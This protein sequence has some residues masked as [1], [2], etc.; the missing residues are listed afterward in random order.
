MEIHD[1]TNRN[2]RKTD[3]LDYTLPMVYDQ[4]EYSVNMKKKNTIN[5]IVRDQLRSMESLANPATIFD[6]DLK[7]LHSKI[8]KLETQISTTTWTQ[9]DEP[10]GKLKESTKQRALKLVDKLVYMKQCHESM[11]SQQ[12]KL[13]EGNGE[14]QNYLNGENVLLKERLTELTAKVEALTPEMINFIRNAK[15]I[16]TT[17][18]AFKGISASGLTTRFGGA[19]N[20]DRIT[21]TENITKHDKF[22]NEEQ[23]KDVFAEPS[24]EPIT[25][26]DATKLAALFHNEIV[27]R[28]RREHQEFN[29]GVDNFSTSV[30]ET[31]R[32]LTNRDHQKQLKTP[33][34]ASATAE[35]LI[36]SGQSFVLFD[37][38]LKG[39]TTTQVRGEQLQVK[40]SQI[41]ALP[42]ESVTK[43]ITELA[44]SLEESKRLIR[45]VIR[46]CDGKV[47]TEFAKKFSYKSNQYA[48]K[49]KE[50]LEIAP[51]AGK[52]K[53]VSA[54]EAS[55]PLSSVNPA[56]VGDDDSEK[57]K[58][59]E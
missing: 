50:L 46:L 9:N 42:L 23:K 56:A 12:Q 31:N 3:Y 16:Y 13:T 37:K 34:N 11:M 7:K 52:A 43:K 45:D 38:Q 40:I 35:K 10:I 30:K 44:A 5:K 25:I 19:R 26:Q 20:V 33:E 22:F 1:K 21:L 41:I 55:A 57:K 36:E 24:S 54:V 4:T 48:D 49:W 18:D 15:A 58:D 39:Y 27:V 8:K 28:S 17:D 32:Q 59:S 47:G 29:S 6:I 2:L 14:I 51:T 53:P